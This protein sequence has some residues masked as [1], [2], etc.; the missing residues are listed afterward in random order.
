MIE[1]IVLGLSG[2]GIFMMGIIIYLISAGW[3]DDIWFRK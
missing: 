3:A 1:Y 2:L